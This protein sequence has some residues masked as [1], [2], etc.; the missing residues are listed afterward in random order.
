MEAAAAGGCSSVTFQLWNS[1]E[2]KHVAQEQRSS[3]ALVQEFCSGAVQGGAVLGG[4]VLGGAVAA[5]S[6]Q[7]VRQWRWDAVSVHVAQLGSAY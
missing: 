4:A 2:C 1:G 5:L 6:A 3:S 7:R